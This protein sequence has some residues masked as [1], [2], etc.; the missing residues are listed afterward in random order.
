MPQINDIFLICFLTIATVLDFRTSRISNIL[1]ISGA[2]AGL[3]VQILMHQMTGIG[4]WF[5]GTAGL[6]T[7]LFVFWLMAVIGAGDI[8]LF[9]VIGGFLGIRAGISIFIL[10]VAVGAVGAAVLIIFRKNLKERLFYSKNY[11]FQLFCLKKSM[12]DWKYMD[13]HRRADDPGAY[14]H[15]SMSILLGTLVYLLR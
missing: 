2:S 15:F 8:K 5:L 7:M 12:S 11:F 1:I 6:V 3:G 13:I 4:Y 10:S 9:G 14:M